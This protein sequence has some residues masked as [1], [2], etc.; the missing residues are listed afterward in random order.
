MR[1]F[2]MVFLHF[3]FVLCMLLSGQSAHSIPRSITTDADDDAG[4]KQKAP[5]P[6]VA[7]GLRKSWGLL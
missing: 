2:F 6:F 4:P 7:V 3:P 5:P 1:S